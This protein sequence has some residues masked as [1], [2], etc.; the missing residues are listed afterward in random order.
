MGQEERSDPKDLPSGS[1]SVMM[2]PI[3]FPKHSPTARLVG[4]RPPV[5]GI[6]PSLTPSDEVDYSGDDFDWGNKCPAPL[7]TIKIFHLT[8][9]E[10]GLLL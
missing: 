4:T 1:P 3:G 8:V 7:D 6:P 2:P 5:I 10:G 9:E